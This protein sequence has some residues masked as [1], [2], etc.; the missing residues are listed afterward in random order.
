VM[1]A[2]AILAWFIG[3]GRAGAEDRWWTLG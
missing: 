2:A 1:V 3:R